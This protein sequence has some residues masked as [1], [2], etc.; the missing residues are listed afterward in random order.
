MQLATA[1][2]SG[3]GPEGFSLALVIASFA[4]RDVR[5]R[6]AGDESVVQEAGTE[7]TPELDRPREGNLEKR[8]RLRAVRSRR[9]DSLFGH[10][11]IR[12]EL[13]VEMK[14]VDW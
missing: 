4:V 12:E 11:L 2:E 5:P 7:P 9:V 1:H 6:V 3:V 10:N 14:Y 8:P 13:L